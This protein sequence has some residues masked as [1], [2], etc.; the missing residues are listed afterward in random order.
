[1]GD[2]ALTLEEKA[3]NFDTSEHIHNV[4]L[5]LHGM[6]LE[7]LSRAM[8]H[9]RSKLQSPEVEAFTITTPKLAGLTYGSDEYRAALREMKPAI[10]HHYAHNRHHPEYF[11]EAG[12]NGMNLLDVLEMLCDWKAATMRHND[13]DIRKSITHNAERFG[14]SPQLVKILENTVNDLIPEGR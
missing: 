12:V 14:L 7:L 3:T 9:D 4:Q 5:L 2:K 1:V 8:A 6:V 13:G 10:E 11:G